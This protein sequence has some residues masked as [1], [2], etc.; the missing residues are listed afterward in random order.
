MKIKSPPLAERKKAPK[1]KAG[2]VHMHPMTRGVM[3]F[4]DKKHAWQDDRIS[5]SSPCLLLP[6]PTAPAAKRRLKRELM[7]E[8]ERIELIAENL[9]AALA[10]SF[11]AK[12]SWKRCIDK[13]HYRE[14]ARTFLHLLEGERK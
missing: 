13:S 11:A 2:V 12:V 3:G 7:S 14:L 9:R 5:G 6:F 8:D 4:Y 1:L 10:P